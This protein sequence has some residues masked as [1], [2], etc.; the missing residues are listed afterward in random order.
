MKE[1]KDKIGEQGVVAII[2][3]NFQPAQLHD[4]AE[5]MFSAGLTIMEVTLNSLNALSAITQLREKYDGR[6]VIGAGTVR[7][8]SQLQQAMAAGAQ[9]TVAPN[10]DRASVETAVAHNF[11]H[12]PG[13]LTPTETE[14]AFQAGCRVLKLFP[15]DMMGPAY[16]KALLAPMDNVKFVPT[17]GISAEN[18]GAYRQVGAFAC[19]IGSALVTGPEQSRADL[20]ARATRLRQ[21]W[22]AAI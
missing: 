5:A 15:S 1:I 22:E 14:I 8:E 16:L 4:I 17:G 2:R 18:I 7:T 21:A 12:L 13:V 9:F 10:F 6:M 11:L 3:G 19:G 20:H